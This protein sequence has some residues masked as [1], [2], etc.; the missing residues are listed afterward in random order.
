MF[1]L[2]HKMLK[3]IAGV[4]VVIFTN[5]FHRGLV[6]DIPFPCINLQALEIKTIRTSKVV[7]N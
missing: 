6:L 3:L 5:I 1:R 4:S 2:V 7:S